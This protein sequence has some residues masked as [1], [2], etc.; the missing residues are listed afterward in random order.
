MKNLSNHLEHSRPSSPREGRTN[1]TYV[2]QKQAILL[3]TEKAYF[4]ALKAQ[5]P[6]CPLDDCEN[7]SMLFTATSKSS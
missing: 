2:K 1:I 5:I 6:R 4:S 7:K 3:N